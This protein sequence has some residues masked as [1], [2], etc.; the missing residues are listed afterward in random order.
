MAR[1]VDTITRSRLPAVSGRP[2]TIYANRRRA[3]RS[4]VPTASVVIPALNAA[5]VIG[6]QL[7]ALS[8]QT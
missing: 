7:D 4:P 2:G 8:R 5:E 1:S 3:P 6:E